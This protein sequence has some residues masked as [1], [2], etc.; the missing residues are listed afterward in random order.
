MATFLLKDNESIFMKYLALLFPILLI[1]CKKDS[2]SINQDEIFQSYVMSY[3]ELSGYT[4]FTANFTY[5]KDDGKRLKL[6]GGSIVTVNGETMSRTGTTYIKRFSGYL[7]SGTFVFTDSEG[8]SYTNTLYYE[9]YIQND[10]SFSLDNSSSYYW[11]FVGPNLSQGETI[12]VTIKSNETDG[13]T[14]SGSTTLD[15][16]SY[17]NISSTQMN[18]LPSGSATASTE[19]S[20]TRYSGNWAKVG[21]KMKSQ[22]SSTPANVSIY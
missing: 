20:T 15:G 2:D 9:D 3:D 6:T 18:L 5:K 13:G 19:R 21:G 10:V 1:S 16:A 4:T 8:K 22:Y 14:A 11:Y 12:T 7:E 17:V